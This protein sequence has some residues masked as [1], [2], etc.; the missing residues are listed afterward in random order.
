MLT[1]LPGVGKTT[2]IRHLYSHYKEKGLRI[3]GITTDE[4]REGDRRIGFKITDLSSG[5]EGWLA[6]VGESEGPRIG[7]YFVVSEDL[8]RIGVGALREAIT[9]NSDLI[10]IDEIGP[11]EMTNKSFRECITNLLSQNRIIVATVKFG[12]HYPEIAKTSSSSE[13]LRIELSTHD[14]DQILQT[15]ISTID[16]WTKR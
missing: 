6:R 8:E 12:S 16:G 3:S 7:K 1:G 11:M 2:L 14:R 10:L 5:E 13:I 9:G 4:V 15:M